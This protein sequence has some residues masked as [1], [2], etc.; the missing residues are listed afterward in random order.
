L[1]REVAVTGVG[2]VSPLGTGRE[3]FWKRLCAGES[4][5]APRSAPDGEAPA[6]RLADFSPRE[7]IHSSHLRRMDD[8]SRM[9]VAAAVL[10][11]A[12]ARA[13]A[14]DSRPA[15]MGIAVGSAFADINDTLE[16]L[17]RLAA[18]GPSLVS[19]MMFPNLVLNA[20]A[21]YAAMEIGCTGA[22][23]TVAQGE[24]SADLA[25]ALGCDLIRS[26]RVDIVLAGGGDQLGN[27]VWTTYERMRALAGQ[28]GGAEWCS[29]Y[30]VDRS[31]L[32]LGE[33]AAILVLESPQHAQRRGAQVYAL[34]EK[35]VGFGIPSSLYDW[36]TEAESAAA[37]LR[38][39]LCD[40]VA[41]FDLVL[42]SANSSRGLDRFEV[43]TIARL[44]GEAAAS[45]SVTSIK[46]AIGEFGAAGALTAAAAVLALRHG[47]VP[48]L[49]NLRQP[50]GGKLQFAGKTAAP[51]ALKQALQ[52]SAARGGGMSAIVYRSAGR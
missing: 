4:G 22:N 13:A 27:I 3:Q 23:F 28:R 37:I 10:A 47:L 40:R 48:P 41:Q 18:K 16:Y 26:G 34:I 35:D 43:E 49:C 31:G 12:D 7:L 2:V 36:P 9:I 17:S 46:G 44:F 1:T 39:R 25:I 24:V 52:L 11:L 33:G 5:I 32:V 29:P 8:A 30:D 6:A 51:R 19:P 14:G 21:S 20:P 45:V 42:G 15:N 50:I 38:E